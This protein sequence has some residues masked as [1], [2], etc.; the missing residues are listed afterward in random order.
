MWSIACKNGNS[1]CL[2]FQMMSPDPYF[3]LHF[4][5]QSITPQPFEIGRIIE[6]VNAECRAN[7]NSA[8]LCI[9]IM[10]P[11]PHFHFIAGLYLS[12]HT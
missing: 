8:N 3:F 11:D 10:S 4:G 7:D 9:L 12:K 5:F 6:Q 1:T 2:C